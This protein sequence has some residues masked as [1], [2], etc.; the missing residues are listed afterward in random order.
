MHVSRCSRLQ[1]FRLAGTPMTAAWELPV[2]FDISCQQMPTYEVSVEEGAQQLVPPGKG[3][4]HLRGREGAVQKQAQPHMRHH[5][6]DRLHMSL[7]V[8]LLVCAVLFACRCAY[9]FCL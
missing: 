9:Y 2:N 5:L 6:R 8:Y 7:C 1:S 4:K 3:T